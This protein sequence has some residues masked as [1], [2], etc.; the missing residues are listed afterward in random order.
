MNGQMTID[1]AMA[2]LV[3]IRTEVVDALLHFKYFI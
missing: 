2:V 3:G 1:T